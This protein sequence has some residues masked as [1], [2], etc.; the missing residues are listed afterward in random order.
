[1]Y[2]HHVDTYGHPKEFG[3]KN[4]IPMFKGE[5]FD[6]VAWAD[7]FTKAGARYVM[8]VAEHHDGFQLY[9][10]DLSEYC[11]TKMGPMRDIVGELKTALTQHNIALAA[12]SHRIEHYFFMSGGRHFDS[13]INDP[14]YGDL[15]WPS[16]HVAEHSSSE[17]VFI[18]FDFMDDWLARTCELVDKYRPKVLYFDWWIHIESMEPYLKKFAA[19]YYNRAD[20]WGEPVAINYKN[21]AFMIRTAV[22]DVERGQLAGISPDFWQCCTSVARRSW[23]YTPDNEYKQPNDLICNL[24]D[25]VSKNGTLLLNVGPKADGTIPDEDRNILLEIG[26]WLDVN[27]EG[28]YETSYWR[29]FGEGPTQTPDGYFTDTKREAYTYEDFRFTCKGNYLY[30]FALKWPEDGVIRI[31]S[32]GSGN[33][34]TNGF[35]GFIKDVRIL[36]FDGDL[37]TIRLKDCLTVIA[38]DL[39]SEHPVCIKMRVG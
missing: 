29:R 13:D 33:H 26:K 20:E 10:S 14:P 2:K 37:R 12:S 24:I 23:S 38:P 17:G 3:Y 35:H 34:N 28:I 6:A 9:D 1:V 21:D 8:P 22:R 5:N 15:Y 4:F 7:L 11:S 31:K 18:E 19:Y 36:G 16:I 30:A 27:G 25:I 32:L 39:K